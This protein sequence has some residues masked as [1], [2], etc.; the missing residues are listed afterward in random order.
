M[1]TNGERD[2]FT[3]EVYWAMYPEAPF[4]DIVMTAVYEVTAK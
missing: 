1:S 3:G 4:N 2:G